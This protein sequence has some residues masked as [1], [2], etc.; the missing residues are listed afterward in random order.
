MDLDLTKHVIVPMEQVPQVVPSSAC[1]E[2]TSNS[3]F[4][5]FDK[6]CGRLVCAQCSLFG[7]HKGHDL[8]DLGEV[9]AESRQQITG[10]V[11]QAEACI[12]RLCVSNKDFSCLSG[13]LHAS[14]TAS[15]DR[16]KAVLEEVSYSFF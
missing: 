10:L 8:R 5:A 3:P 15:I 7:S 13:A 14:L 4:I 2:H 6:Q 11:E 9:C 16:I 1:P 12:A